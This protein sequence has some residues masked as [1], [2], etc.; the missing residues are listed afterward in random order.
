M[1]DITIILLIYVY[2]SLYSLVLMNW[3]LTSTHLQF[4]PNEC[5]NIHQQST[6]AL[7]KE[8]QEKVNVRMNEWMNEY[9][10]KSNQT[11]DEILFSLYTHSSMNLGWGI[12]KFGIK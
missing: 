11:E 2:V 6:S 8:R 9:I 3:I 12:D 1:A 10:S 4:Q 7:E 5:V